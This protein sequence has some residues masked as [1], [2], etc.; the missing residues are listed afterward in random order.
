M[1]LSLRSIYVTVNICDIISMH[2]A[3]YRKEIKIPHGSENIRYI[4]LQVLEIQSKVTVW[5]C[6]CCEFQMGKVTCVFAPKL[7]IY[8]L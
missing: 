5:V 1:Y 3:M 7:S 4:F 2:V 8:T 6:C